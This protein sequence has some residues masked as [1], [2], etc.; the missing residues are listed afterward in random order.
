MVVP[1]FLPHLGCR[2]RCIYCHQGYI[3]DIRHAD[4]KARIDAAF[5]GRTETCDVGLFGGNIFGVDPATLK[6][7]F[8]FFAPYRGLI[9]GFRLSTK[10]VPLRGETIALL[11]KNNVGLIELGVP[12]FNDAILRFLNRMHTGDDLFRAYDRLRRDGFA[13][14]L[15]FM[16][17]LPGETGQD[18]DDIIRYM[19]RL[20]P[21]YIRVYPLVVLKNTPL[22]DLYESG[23][24]IPAAFDDVLD[25][26]CRIYSSAVQNGIEVANVG[27][28]DNELVRDMVA[29]GFYHP[30]YGFLV[31]SRLFKKALESA[32][33][34]LD[35]PSEIKAIIHRND[36]PLLVGHKRQNIADFAA[37]GIKISWDPSGDER[38]RF[39]II[40][41][42]KRIDSSV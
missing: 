35:Y 9:K 10:P 31:Q 20:K 21:S 33:S 22:H 19:I 30:A 42:D 18:I 32:I 28:T 37:K 15:Q 2:E 3:T 27:L 41:G 39:T 6:A 38:G 8:S 12:T 1:V 29:G 11:K 14:A 5:R 16:V 13:L 36:I 24:F 40:N 23:E 4:I 7:I 25:R 34:Q 17:G 26:A